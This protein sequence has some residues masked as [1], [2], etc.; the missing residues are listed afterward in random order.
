MYDAKS[1][2]LTISLV[3]NKIAAFGPTILTP[4]ITFGAYSI[5]RM[6]SHQS[7]LSVTTAVTSLS[8]ISLITN[9]AK[10]L[11]I[12]IPMGLQAIGSFDRIQAFLQL[13][14]T[15]ISPMPGS[16]YDVDENRFHEKDSRPDRSLSAPLLMQNLAPR[17]RMIGAQAISFAPQMLIAITG[18]IGCGKSTV[19]KGLLSEEAQA[20]CPFPTEDKTIAYCGQTPWIHDGT[21][22]DN[23]IGQSGFDYLWYQKVIYS[24]ALDVDIGRMPEADSTVVGSKGLRLSGGQK[25]RIVSGLNPILSHLSMFNANNSLHSVLPALCTPTRAGPFLTMLQVLSM[26]VHFLLWRIRSLVPT[27]YFARMGLQ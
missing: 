9:P 12:A 21:I 23:I 4:L 6:L 2:P 19:L 13:V 24:C 16:S 18:P 20:A 26:V 1:L 27:A 10:Q 11:L 15:P 7:P 14:V 3:L 5:M 8:I 17:H 25:Q 22:R